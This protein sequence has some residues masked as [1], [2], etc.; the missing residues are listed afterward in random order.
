[1]NP[2]IRKSVSLCIALAITT[3]G[4]SVSLAAANNAL[5]NPPSYATQLSANI[6]L[7]S[8]IYD[9]IAKLDGLGYLK[10]MPTG[11]KPYTRMQVARWVEQIDSALATD[12][13][14][15][16]YAK[17][18]ASELKNEFKQEL[19]ILHGAAAQQTLKLT[20]WK[21]A[22][23]Y[24]HGSTLEQKN[25][26]STYQPL[27]INNNGYRYA[28]GANE[29]FSFNLAGKLGDDLVMSL[30]PHLSY[31]NAENS[32]LTLESGYIKTRINNVAIQ[33]GKD[34][35]SWGQGTR[36]NLLYSNNAE[37]QTAI[38]FSNIEPV[39][40]GGIFKFLGKQNT[41]VSYS[42]METNREI[43]YPSFFAFRLDFTPSDNFTFALSQASIVGGKGHSLH[44]FEDLK[45]Y[46]LG[47]NGGS[48]YQP[49][50]KWNTIAGGD[51]RWRIPK[52]NGIQFYGEIYGEDQHRR[53]IP[54][55]YKLAQIVGI[56][57]PRF[58]ADGSWD[59]N[60]E[61]HHTNGY[62]YE[63]WTYTDGW[64]YRG[65]IM[66]DAIGNNAKSYYEKL[67]HYNRDGSQLSFNVEQVKMQ[68]TDNSPQKID[69]VWLAYRTKLC[70]DTFLDLS[71]GYA[72]ISNVSYTS[73]NDS[74]NY[75]LGI[76]IT[77]HY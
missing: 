9:Y 7:D 42:I 51:F 25:T 67:T 73:G 14:A 20:E 70:T 37:A 75:S 29:M 68:Y 13:S 8:Y 45:D 54:Y 31:D 5:P 77:K 43:P 50:D 19:A 47:R 64:T 41:T 57:I 59:A 27:N 33:M 72:N 66:G 74:H 69:S 53:V 2:T 48:K 52:W 60:F 46:F 32:E 62:W 34:P 26:K 3:G 61:Y 76:G 17:N 35:V 6:S 28:D 21:F 24:Y 4:T 71:A 30:T 58:T 12:Q 11:T 1:M 49:V 55:P 18:M 23:D 40:T 38:K 63:N 39:Q 22:T 15:P 65:D 36:G 10:D 44:G 16:A 56:Y